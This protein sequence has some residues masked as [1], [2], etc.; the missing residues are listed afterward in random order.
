M[1][2]VEREKVGG[3]G[4]CTAAA[5]GVVGDSGCLSDSTAMEGGCTTAAFGGGGGGGGGMAA[6]PASRG[7]TIVGAG[8]GGG[9]GRVEGPFSS[10]WRVSVMAAPTVELRGSHERSAG[11]SHDGGRMM[12]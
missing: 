3:G 9:V 11:G 4:S 2:S 5:F 10:R 12:T 6:R 1:E 8:G 7:S